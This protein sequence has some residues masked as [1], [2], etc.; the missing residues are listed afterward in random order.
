MW[1]IE[2]VSAEELAKLFHHYQGAL[3]HDFDC[4]NEEVS[5]TWNR[6]P[7][8]ERKRLVAAARLALLE[9]ANAPAPADTSDDDDSGWL[10]HLWPF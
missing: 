7:P 1:S 6:T 3:A 9:L 8:Q 10:G 4:Q 2:N 5:S